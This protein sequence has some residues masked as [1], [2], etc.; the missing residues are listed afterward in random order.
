MPEEPICYDSD[1]FKNSKNKRRS[2]P[3]KQYKSRL[4]GHTLHL[5]EKENPAKRGSDKFLSLEIVRTA[6]GRKILYEEYRDCRGRDSHVWDEIH[7]GRVEVIPPLT[8]G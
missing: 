7:R 5:K 1:P 3:Q 6:P 2:K 4:V 8:S